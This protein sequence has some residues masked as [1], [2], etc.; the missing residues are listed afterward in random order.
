MPKNLLS[1]ITNL[2][3][4]LATKYVSLVLLTV[5]L[6]FTGK[7]YAQVGKGNDLV[8][9]LNSGATIYSDD[10]HF[11]IQILNKKIILKNTDTQLEIDEKKHVLKLTGKYSQNKTKNEFAKQLKTTE[12]KCSRKTH[13]HEEKEA[14][15]SAQNRP[16]FAEFDFTESRSSSQLFSSHSNSKN[17]IIPHNDSKEVSELDVIA[18]HHAAAKV[19]HDLHSQRCTYYNNKSLNFC[20][21]K[22]FSV[23]PPPVY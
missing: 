15:N 1:G 14:Q 2:Y 17:F 12:N 23:R 9:V 3:L 7:I 21:S 20:Y 10:E 8:L 11:N 5:F 4:S 19:L 6:L 16:N 13:L 22:V 18:N